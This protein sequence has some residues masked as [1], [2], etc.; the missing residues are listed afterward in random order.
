LANSKVE[1]EHDR[2]H[3]GEESPQS[4]S[5]LIF[6]DCPFVL[7]MDSCIVDIRA[8]VVRISFS[9]FVAILAWNRARLYGREAFLID[10]KS[11]CDKLPE[12]IN[13]NVPTIPDL[14]LLQEA[15][16]FVSCAGKFLLF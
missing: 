7:R 10:Q 1:A 3:G 4:K 16:Q 14:W 8:H 2:A 9:F 6:Q 13:Q 12:C 5:P 15:Y 11:K